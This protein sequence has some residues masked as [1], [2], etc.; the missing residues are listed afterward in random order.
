LRVKIRILL[1]RWRQFWVALIGKNGLM[2]PSRVFRDTIRNA[3]KFKFVVSTK[4][5]KATA[6]R[7]HFFIT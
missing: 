7:P 3:W 2:L 4:V 1:N 5:D 6:E